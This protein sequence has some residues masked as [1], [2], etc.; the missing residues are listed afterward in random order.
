MDTPVDYA[1]DGAIVTVTLNQP[2]TRNAFTDLDVVDVLVDAIE[3]LNA[4]PSVRA[5]S[6]TSAGRAS[7]RPAFGSSIRLRLP[8]TRLMRCA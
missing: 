3:R 2:A 4:D 7:T 8:P 1:Q 5:A 6:L